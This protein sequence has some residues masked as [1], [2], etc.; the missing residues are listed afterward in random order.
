[1]TFVAAALAASPQTVNVDHLVT[2]VGQGSL[3]LFLGAGVSAAPPSSGPMGSQV[4][5]GVLPVVSAWHGVDG[6]SLRGLTL[7]AL[8][9]RLFAD[10]PSARGRLQHLLA[11]SF[12]FREMRPNH[13][14]FV[15]AWLLL[16]GV[17]RLVTTNWDQ[18][19]ETAARELGFEAECLLTIAD[20]QSARTRTPLKKLHGC[21]S[22]PASLRISQEEVDEAGAWST[23]IIAASVVSDQVVFI[24]YGT[25]AKYVRKPIQEALESCPGYAS[26]VTVVSRSAPAAWR[27]LLDGHDAARVIEADAETFLDCLLR[28]LVRI[29]MDRAGARVGFLAQHE[30]WGPAL[31]EGLSKLVDALGAASADHVLRWWRSAATSVAPGLPFAASPQG[32]SCLI[33][34]GHFAAADGHVAF[35]GGGR[36]SRLETSKRF[37]E[38]ASRPGQHFSQARAAVEGFV[39]SRHVD[40]VYPD[41][42]PVTVVLEGVDGSFPDPNAVVDIAALAADH[43]SIDSNMMN[44]LH[45]VSASD[46]LS[47]RVA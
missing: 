35:T 19:I 7:E 10:D 44:P 3:V 42:R 46:V 39:R 28:A 27:D 40:G 47:G 4:A 13:A 6:A 2:A 17:A 33:A 22:S 14:H 9:S 11:D 26:A 8:A 16:E 43:A 45:F 32:A 41:A 15:S 20:D 23:A 31:Q 1:M 34:A 25:I 12:G 24:G 36:S 5:D 29:W 21:S 38:I 37:L 18:A 30:S